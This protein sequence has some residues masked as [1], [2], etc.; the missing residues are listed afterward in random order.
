MYITEK[1]LLK[2]TTCLS[3]WP[4]PQGHTAVQSDQQQKHTSPSVSAAG[5]VS[6]SSSCFFSFFLF[7][8][9]FFSSADGVEGAEG[10]AASLSLSSRFLWKT[11]T[12]FSP[13]HYAH[14]FIHGINYTFGVRANTFQINTRVST[15]V[16]IPLL[17]HFHQPWI[18]THWKW[19]GNMSL[20]VLDS[21][22]KTD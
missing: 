3:L 16:S 19:D 17:H 11:E 18:W 8:F 1:L 13:S 5:S 10:A 21:F 20:F 14:K 7:F 4:E 12:S 22:L 9:S 2:T 15:H 6:A